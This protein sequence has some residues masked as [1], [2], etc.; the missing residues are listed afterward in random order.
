MLEIIVNNRVWFFLLFFAVL[1]CS[2][3]VTWYLF[4]LQNKQKVP[5]A[6][7][8]NYGNTETQNK[9]AYQIKNM[10][11]PDGVNPNPLSYFILNDNGRDVFVRSFSIDTM[12]KRA[13]FAVTFATLFN[14]E[15]VISS[16]YI[17]PMSEAVA[18]NMLDKTV[19]EIE[20]NM[21]TA[22]KSGNSNSLRKLRG[23]LNE[24]E[25]WARKVETGENTFYQVG[26]LFTLF[27]DSLEELNDKSD[28]FRNLAKE[29]QIGLTSCYAVQPEAYLSNMPFNTLF[30]SSYGVV[31][32][33]GIK[34]HNM[35]KLSIATIF[36]HVQNDFYH[37]H[38]I[39]LGRNM[40]SWKPVIYDCYDI[41][42]NGYNISFS[43]MTG[44]GKSA[45]IKI[46]ASR[47]MSKSNFRFVCIDS[48]LKGDRGE[49]SM[50]ADIVNGVI[51]KIGN[52]ENIQNPF[53]LDVEVGWSEINGEYLELRLQDKIVQVVSNI[54]M[55]IQGTKEL[56]NFELSVYIERIVT[57]ITALLY[58]EA[59]IKDGDPDS[60]FETGKGIIDGV[61]SSGRKK[62][63]LP[64]LSDFYQ[65]VV[66]KNYENK[67]P[68][69]KKA[70]RIILDTLKDRVREL[71]YCPDCISFY[72]KE[73]VKNLGRKCRCNGDILSVFGTR[74]YYDGQST[75][76]IKQSKFTDIDI[77]A[78]PEDERPI[79]R[80]ISMSFIVEAF[81][82]KNATNPKKTEK[83][84]LI[85]DE[86]HENFTSIFSVRSLDYTARTSRKRLV[87]LW[88]ATQ[89]LKDYSRMPETE[90]LL[91][92][93]VTK[94]VFKQ[95][96]QD[97][98][99]IKQALNLTTGQV[100]KVLELGGDP[101]NKDDLYARK[102]E[103]CIVDNDRVCFCKVD[104]LKDAE[105]IFVETDPT[106]LKKM[107]S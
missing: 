89:A 53:E 57:D 46:L 83:L 105:A 27:A 88:T 6:N 35:D 32:S 45:T 84:A 50:L 61:M 59:K 49:Y 102:G 43:G 54:M 44:T 86:A 8:L 82:K 12:P 101:S 10:L 60:L 14:F 106:I 41:S 30:R 42:H 13:V 92:Q 51:Y 103:V 81:I 75:V 80:Q 78:L 69:H 99:W 4:K 19:V 52:K 5:P 68:E 18:A 29:R 104:Y 26:F 65:K 70:Y 64:T 28:T 98:D 100:E 66:I 48:Q 17:H 1:I 91:K 33:A 79:A 47:F 72:S 25:D 39:I 58:K 74:C 23:K 87:S 20:T 22:Q 11:A 9:E 90:A 97:K 16:V 7:Y 85:V 63:R 56:M 94:F 95:S 15:R 34:M 24:T 37:R 36:N 107:Y 67:L 21:I 73:E 62:K 55:L 77:S 38:G 2:I 31:K 71:H 96:Y 93:A 76:E 3:L 40:F